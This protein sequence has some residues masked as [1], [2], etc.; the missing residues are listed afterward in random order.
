[1]PR[2]AAGKIT[3]KKKASESHGLEE[4]FGSQA[5]FPCDCPDKGTYSVRENEKLKKFLLLR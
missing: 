3:R 1:L 2:S 4:R 5:V